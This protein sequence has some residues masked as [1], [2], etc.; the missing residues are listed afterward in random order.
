MKKYFF[1]IFSFLFSAAT[2]SQSSSINVMTFNIRLD[3]KSDSLNGWQYRKERVAKTVLLNNVDIVGM[4]EVLHN[5]LMDIEKALPDYTWIG[6]GR[7][8]GMEAGEYSPIFYNHN[9]FSEVG[10][11]YF[12]LSKTPME[13]G[14]KGWDAACTRIATWAKLKDISTGTIFFV[15]NT[16]FDHIG[17]VARRESAKLILEKVNLYTQKKKY[18]IIVMGDFNSNAQSEAYKTLTDTSNPLYLT[19]T[20]MLATKVNGPSWTFHNFGRQPVKERQMIDY[21][22]VNN[23][24]KV[25]SF[26]V[27]DGTQ[28]KEYPS[29]HNAVMVKVEF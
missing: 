13:A 4:Q 12:W 5:Q 26:D 14:S 17:E 10:S 3:V 1:L 27:I 28:T 7:E 15:L 25:L 16:H 23:G 11:G 22:F 18:P 2:Y 9:K 21:I 24:I 6:V 8:D 19:D 20:R 29:D